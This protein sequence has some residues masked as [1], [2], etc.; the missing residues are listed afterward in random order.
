MKKKAIFNL[1]KDI[2]IFAVAFAILYAILTN[3]K[4]MGIGISGET[5]KFLAYCIAGIPCGWRWASH[6]LTAVSG[7]GILLKLA[8]SVILGWL[9]VPVMVI[10][11]IINLIKSLKSP[12]EGEVEG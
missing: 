5:G 12:I 6:L 9:A 3:E 1:V 7:K 2:L 4:L 10:K 11:D 8:I